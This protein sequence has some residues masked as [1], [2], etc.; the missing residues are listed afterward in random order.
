MYQ[1]FSDWF[2]VMEF[3]ISPW[4]ASEPQKHN[5]GTAHF[6][7][8]HKS[9]LAE[10]ETLLIAIQ[11]LYSASSSL[12]QGKGQPWSG[13]QSLSYALTPL[14]CIRLSV[15]RLS[16]GLGS[17]TGLS[18]CVPRSIHLVLLFD[19]CLLSKLSFFCKFL[20]VSFSTS[21]PL[22]SQISLGLTWL[23]YNT[24]CTAHSAVL[25]HRPIRIPKGTPV[26]PKSRL[27]R[28]TAP[29]STHRHSFMDGNTGPSD[30]AP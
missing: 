12:S 28:L 19:I 14:R 11:S 7:N 27:L 22:P 16:D 13:R 25:R 2:R 26:T 17:R 10:T 29:P 20:I 24:K 21:F 9:S 4:I 3:G 18:R 1:T 30:L 23:V 5:Y 6:R 15:A 8:T